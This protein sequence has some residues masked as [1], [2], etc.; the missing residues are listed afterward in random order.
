[1]SETTIIAKKI[2]GA[3]GKISDEYKQCTE[4]NPKPSYKIDGSPVTEADIKI[5]DFLKSYLLETEEQWLSEETSEKKFNGDLGWIVDP[6]DGT[7]EYTQNIPEWAVSIAYVKNKKIIAA[8]IC[9]PRL[10]ISVI[11]Y[12]SKDSTSHFKI[13]GKKPPHF[14]PP[15]TLLVS[16][17]ELKRGDWDNFNPAPLNIV[18][19]GSI[20]NKICMLLAGFC[21]AVISLRP[22]NVWDIAAGVG[23]IQM[24]G[25]V[26][27]DLNGDQLTYG[28]MVNKPNG[29]ILFSKPND[30]YR[31]TVKKTR[32][33]ID[34]IN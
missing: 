31:V 34:S 15:P 12:R 24:L 13:S 29:L 7:K 1:M 25:G 9:N 14:S 22:K 30:L 4:K 19:C 2:I 8:G 3:F 16:R 27:E 11:G 28:K 33:F 18:P 21:D 32:K 17:S 10:S 5:N 26:A 20:A 6:I 23:L